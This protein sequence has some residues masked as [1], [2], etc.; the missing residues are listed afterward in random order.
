MG[1]LC[2]G[3]LGHLHHTLTQQ[4]LNEIGR[5]DVV[6][7]PVDGSMTLDLD[8]MIDVLKSLKAQVMIPMHFFSA[9]TLDRFLQRARQEW[10]VEALE[11]PST[12]LS[13]SSLPAKPKVLVLPG[14]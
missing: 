14:H 6:F 5:L 4:Q 3:H 11:V 13:K 7:V 2:I 8:G 10:D 12:V 9:Y 1:T